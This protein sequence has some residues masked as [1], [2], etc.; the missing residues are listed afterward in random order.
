LLNSLHKLTAPLS[1]SYIQYCRQCD[2]T[3]AQRITW[4]SETNC[5]NP[6]SWNCSGKRCYRKWSY[7]QL[8]SQL[9]QWII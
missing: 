7:V 2:K 6:F 1:E 8:H 4:T 5:W 3:Q 9:Q